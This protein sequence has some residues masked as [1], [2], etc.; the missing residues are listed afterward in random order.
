MTNDARQIL[1][2][3]IGDFAPE[4]FSSFFRNKS[5]QYAAREADLSQYNDDNFATGKKQGEIKFSDG[6]QLL[7]CTFAAQIPLSERSG[8]KAQYEKAKNILKEMQVYAAGI[9]IFYDASGNF[10]FSLVYPESTG[11]KRQWNNFR[12]F[13]YFV[14]AEFTNKTFLNRIGDGNFETLQKVKD[15]FAVGPVTDLFYKEFFFEYV[16]LV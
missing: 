2:D 14:S 1:E 9:F 8:K 5:R 16:K 13:T 3:I 4:K 10:R 6:D 7:I 15:A 12:R 11:A